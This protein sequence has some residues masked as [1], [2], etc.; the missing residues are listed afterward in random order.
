MLFERYATEVIVVNCGGDPELLR[1]LPAYRSGPAVR[2][3]NLPGAR[4]NWSLAN[5]IGTL[6]STSNVLFFLDADIALQ[7]D[8]FHEALP[9]LKRGDCFVHVRT[10]R[11]R[12]PRESGFGSSYLKETVHFHHL[13]F[14]DGQRA[15]LRSEG[16]YD[17]SRGGP[18]L[19]L[20]N[21]R[22]VLAV[23]GFNSALEGW[24]FKDKDMHIRLQL[25]LRLK[26]R[27][28]GT[29]QHLTHG[30]ELRE[31]R[32][33]SRSE[34]AQRIREECFENY[35]RGQLFGTYEEDVQVWAPKL[36]ETSLGSPAESRA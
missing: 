4:F 27:A 31:V 12:Q 25:V 30:D 24:G 35:R 33:A 13:I 14:A 9:M 28:T 5:N 8:V 23:G 2:H 26:L 6:C 15:L 36:K 21:K 7:S 19:M 1:E 20:L 32:G 22:H 34:D 17:G 16:S 3:I 18:G 29:V 10:V 11:E